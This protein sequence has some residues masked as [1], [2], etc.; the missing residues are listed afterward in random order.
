M[1][2]SWCVYFPLRFYSLSPWTTKKGTQPRRAFP[3]DDGLSGFLCGV[4][5]ESGRALW[6]QGVIGSG[7]PTEWGSGSHLGY[8][9]EDES[10]YLSCMKKE[11]G[12]FQAPGSPALHIQSGQPAC[13]G[14]GPLFHLHVIPAINPSDKLELSPIDMFTREVHI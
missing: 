4:I 3:R 9:S 11:G 7:D 2:V 10:C 5:T 14:A 8:F 6:R 13:W 1:F 12:C